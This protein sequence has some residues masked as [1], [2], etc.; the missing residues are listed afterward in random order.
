MS[1]LKIHMTYQCTAACDHCRF[2]CTTDSAPVID[3][4]M[5]MRC[6]TELKKL[7]NLDLVVLLGGEP[8]LFPELT[9]ALTK[10]IRELD[11]AARIETNASYAVSEEQAYDF[12]QPL[13]ALDA[14][15]MFSL[16]AFH[17]DFIP[18]DRIKNAIQV[19]HTEGGQYCL[20]MAYLNVS[21]QEHPRDQRTDA[22]LTE[23]K[24]Q[25]P[26]YSPSKI[27]QGNVLFNGRA[28]A[29]LAPL[30]SAGR[31]LPEDA[32]TTVPWWHHGE[33]DT[34]ELLILDA[35]GFLSKGCGIA[36]ANINTT[37]VS[38]MLHNFD[39]RQHPIFSVLMEAGPRGFLKEAEALG[40]MRK[41]DYADKCH[42]CQEVRE[43]LQSRHPE[44]LTPAQ[45]YS[46][47][48]NSIL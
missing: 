40:Y 24:Q 12:L 29:K 18:L 44:Y 2:K 32:C 26:D 17:E 25:L 34:L 31:G 33:L 38:Q 22:L 30:V 42:L 19:S 37:P 43:V 11:I 4:D 20:E 23:L 1:V 45:H 3:F 5:A 47:Q 9:H 35:E 39:A 14:S 27:Y 7:N 36:I 28:A 46:Y 6:V 41:P 21:S 10:A 48:M 15:V 8:G 13:Y 16:D